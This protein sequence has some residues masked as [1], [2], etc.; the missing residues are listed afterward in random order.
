MKAVILVLICSLCHAG[1]FT[2]T[3]EIAESIEIP[4][5]TQPDPVVRFVVPSQV[6]GDLDM[7]G[8][9]QDFTLSIRDLFT[10]N[11]VIRISEIDIFA[12]RMLGTCQTLSFCSVDDFTTDPSF[13]NMNV[14]TS[15]N[16]PTIGGSTHGGVTGTFT[17]PMFGFWKFEAVPNFGS[18]G[19]TYYVPEPTSGLLLFL[20]GLFLLSK[21]RHV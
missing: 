12:T 15:I 7:M 11:G 16:A 2:N 19:V 3:A 9:E 5:P 10:P 18:S 14:T 20:A 4:A 1:T 6:G 21:I 8:G 17:L 13:T